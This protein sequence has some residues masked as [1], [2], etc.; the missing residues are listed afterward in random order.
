MYTCIHLQQART[1]SPISTLFCACRA[2]RP[3]YDND[4]DDKDNDDKGNDNDD[5]DDND[6][7]DDKATLSTRHPPE[8]HAQGPGCPVSFERPDERLL[9]SWQH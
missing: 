2:V 3:C 8:C 9:C 1:S 7:D 5:N 6:N 4:N